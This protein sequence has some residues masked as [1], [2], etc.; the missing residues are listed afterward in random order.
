MGLPDI[1]DPQPIETR[2]PVPVLD[3]AGASEVGAERDRNDD[4]F[5]I[6]TLRRAMLVHDTSLGEE[7]RAWLAGGNEGTL[8]VVAEGVGGGGGVA[9]RVAVQSIAEYFL[10]VM[11]WVTAVRTTAEAATTLPGIHE[12]L[13]WALEAGDADIHV[14]AA[15]PGAAAL[16]GTTLTMAYLVWPV[17]Y[18]AHVGDSRCYLH[19]GGELRRMT[20]DATPA[21]PHPAESSDMN[22][23]SPRTH[24]PWN[25]VG[26]GDDAPTPQIRKAFMEPGSS[27]LL[28]TNGLTDRISE[29][30]IASVLRTNAPAKAVCERL[31][32][33]A[34]AAGAGDDV[35]VVV[36]RACAS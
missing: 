34:Q 25:L 27:V 21:Q 18:V 23:S 3:L 2:S 20:M 31:V 17:V 33:H 28:C 1:L 32:S 6:A 13:T 12:Q 8:L 22:P 19:R 14:H 11:P 7:D 29:D 15:H 10:E 30:E 24:R 26:G 5:L 16:V 9:S 35:T 36:A 4:A